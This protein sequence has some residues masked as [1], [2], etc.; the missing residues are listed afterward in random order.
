METLEKLKIL[1]G[2][3]RYDVSCASSGAVRK[4]AQGHAQTAPG[5]CHSW[6]ADG[7]C[8]S[9][10]KV[11]FTNHCRYDCKYCVNRRSNDVVRTAFTPR[12]LAQLTSDFYLRNYVEGLF[13]S[14]GVVKSPDFTM[15]LLLQ[16]VRLLRGEYRFQGYIHLKIIPG[17]SS[18]LVDEA[19]RLA[20]RVSVNVEFASQESLT[21]MAPDKAWG[22][23]M[24]PMAR[25]SQAILEGALARKTPAGKNR[26]SA[27]GQSTQLIVGATP[28]DDARILTLA[29]R[30]Y[31][32]ERLKR[33]YYS[34][35]VPVNADAPS[36]RPPLLREH[37]LYQAD[38]LLRMY[39]FGLGEIINPQDGMLDLA[40]DPKAAWAIR[41]L[42]RFPLEVNKASYEELLRVPGLG[43]RSA[44][45]IVSERRFS[46]LT[47]EHLKRMNVVM[48]RAR[49]FL[50]AGGLY[51]G[52]GLS[53]ALR[54]KEKLIGIEAHNVN[55]QKQLTFLEPISSAEEA[56]SALTG[57]L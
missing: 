51:G 28:E 6:S 13:L 21:S 32:K 55:P 20:D 15:G 26:L 45:R 5:V 30:L 25:A 19:V 16:T 53:D 29:D 23:V 10:L 40:L 37:R 1:A 46:R 44:K 17:A 18:V 48:K 33:V 4:N 57:E 47:L 27:T 11:L 41:N 24:A 52:D 39:G 49:H 3:A 56:W 7:R 9:L 38:W 34:A 2:S 14:S 8:I 22:N 36:A 43:I 42:A 50:T 54:V 35:Y 31:Q 12:E